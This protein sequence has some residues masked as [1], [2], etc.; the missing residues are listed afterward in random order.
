M[1]VGSRGSSYIARWDQLDISD[2][3]HPRLTCS[4]DDLRKQ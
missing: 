3:D 4:R 2:P 1:L